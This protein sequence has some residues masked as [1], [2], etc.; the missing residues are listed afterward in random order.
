MPKS[1][2]RYRKI[3]RQKPKHKTKENYQTT[4]V[5]EKKK[6]QRSKKKSEHNKM[7]VST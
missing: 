4:R 3:K 5:Q 1:N 6:D 7:A 2:N